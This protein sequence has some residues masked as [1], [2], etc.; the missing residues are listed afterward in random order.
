MSNNIDKDLLSVIKAG[1]AALKIVGQVKL[2]N[3]SDGR[4][5]TIS[6]K[7]SL[8]QMLASGWWRLIATKEDK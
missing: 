4:V 6:D 7:E 8:K 3:N 5:E 2:S 1:E